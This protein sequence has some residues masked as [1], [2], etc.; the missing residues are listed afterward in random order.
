MA[1]AT[2]CPALLLAVQSSHTLILCTKQKL[3]VLRLQP[4]HEAIAM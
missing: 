4:A 2:G 3:V 1:A